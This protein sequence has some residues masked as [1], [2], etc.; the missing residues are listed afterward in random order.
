MDKAIGPASDETLFKRRNDIEEIPM[1]GQRVGLFRAGTENAI[2]LNRVGSMLWQ[3]LAT[4]QT[5]TSLVS[6]LTSRFP[7]IESARVEQDV[8]SY[9]E[10]LI[11]RDIISRI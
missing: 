11:A 8:T 7:S 6:H 4:P 5:R 9:L 3:Q 1:A 10:L 2:V